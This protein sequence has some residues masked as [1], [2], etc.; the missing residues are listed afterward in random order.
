MVAWLET[1]FGSLFWFSRMD[2]WLARIS[3]WLTNTS[4]DMEGPRW[5]Q[6]LNATGTPRRGG[7]QPPEAARTAGRENRRKSE[8]ARTARP[9][10]GETDS[11]DARRRLRRGLVEESA[12][13]KLGGDDAVAP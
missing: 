8:R 11:G 3:R 10:R 13:A 2:R 1:I 5:K 7:A 12:D 9:P 6:S 4:S